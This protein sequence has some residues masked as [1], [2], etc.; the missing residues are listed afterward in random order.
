MNKKIII[1]PAD[2]IAKNFINILPSSE[3]VPEW[4]K[5][6][7]SKTFDQSSELLINS[8]QSTNSTYKKCTPFF[9]AITAGYMVFLSADV[10][11][12]A[13]NFNPPHI[14]YRT[15]T[16]VVTDHIKEQWR[17]LPSPEGYVD[18][19]Y[20]WENQFIVRTP[21]DYSLLFL[22]P[23]N[24]FDLPFQTI[25][26]IVDTDSYDLQVNFPFFIKN[27]FTGIIKKGT[28]IT[29]IIPIKRDSWQREINEYDSEELKTSVQ[30]FFSTIKR[31]YKNNY[32]V[33][34][35]YR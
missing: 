34:K 32:W 35:Q 29:Q 16:P 12:V 13:S 30:N 23:I 18:H 27:N 5:S 7:S 6:S 19:V 22:N 11:V 14:L 26:G 24:R 2:E 9:D 20:K 10:E 8:P 15:P 28:P 25:S 33:K 17:G 4:Y 3:F 1:Q 21:K 31:S